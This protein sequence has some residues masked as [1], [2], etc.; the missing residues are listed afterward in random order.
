[1]AFL[2]PGIFPSCAKFLKHIL[3]ILYFLNTACTLPQSSH[4][5]YFLTLNLG[6]RFAFAII[7]FLATFTPY[8]ACLL[9]GIPRCLSNANASAL[10][11]ALVT[12]IISIPFNL[13]ILSKLIS[14]NII[15]SFT[16]KAKLP[17]P[18]KLL[19]LR[20]LKSLTRGSAA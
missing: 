1:L 12:I 13:R 6:S 7:D 9:N 3:Q 4:L 15:S 19:W 16:P 2:T 10:D 20:P 11:F 8:Y 5:V 18:S 14:G 17:L